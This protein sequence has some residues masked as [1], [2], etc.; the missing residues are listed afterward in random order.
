MAMNVVSVLVAAGS[1]VVLALEGLRLPDAVFFLLSI[2]G[3]AYWLFMRSGMSWWVSREFHKRPDANALV[4]W[5][6]SEE[7]IKTQCK[8]LASSEFHWKVFLNIVETRDGFLFYPH[9]RSFTGCRSAFE[10]PEG[11][12]HVRQF[13][14]SHGLKYTITAG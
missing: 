13:A 1:I 8:G 7:E 10:R 3:A 9:R 6:I 11:I 5:E 14:K 2:A 12:E 4:E